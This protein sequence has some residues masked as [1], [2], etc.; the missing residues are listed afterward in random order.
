M[1]QGK[2]IC[3]C[4]RDD[5]HSSKDCWTV[6]KM[7]KKFADKCADDL[8]KDGLVNEDGTI[9]MAEWKNMNTFTLDDFLNDTKVE[10]KRIEKVL[11]DAV[12]KIHKRK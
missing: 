12:D 3:E 11:G 6:E 1:T 9:P 2:T 10:A 8:V 4:G 7:I 5:I